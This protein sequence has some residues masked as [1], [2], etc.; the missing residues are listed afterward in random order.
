MKKTRLT[1]TVLLSI[2]LL[3]VIV[4]AQLDLRQGSQQ[5]IDWTVDIFEPFLQAL[6]GPNDY[7]GL[8]VFERLLIFVLLM[9]IITISLK[10]ISVFDDYPWIIGLIAVIISLVAVRYMNYEWLNT[11]LISYQILGIAIAGILPF[12][13]YLFFINSFDNSTMRKVGWIFF[14]VVYFGLWATNETE[15]YASIYFW[16]M[17]IAL[18]FLILDGT[19]H[20]YY[21]KEY[22]ANFPHC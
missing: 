15:N 1:L 19:I 9:S 22:P 12:I 20:E 17:L 16:T 6:L 3:S 10:N 11:V 4:S 21:D 2:I 7:S 13:I 14:I 18:I 8:L 5:I